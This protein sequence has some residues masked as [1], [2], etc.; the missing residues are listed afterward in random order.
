MTA[1]PLRHQRANGSRHIIAMTMQ[2]VG[3]LVIDPKTVL[4]WLASRLGASSATV[5]L[6]VPIREAGAL[7]PQAALLAFV[8]RRSSRK[9]LWTAGAFGQAATVTGLA[10][11]AFLRP[12]LPGAWILGLMVAFALARSLSSLTSKDVL[13]RTIP[14]GSRGRVSGT[15]TAASGLVVISVGA[16]LRAQPES[17]TPARTLGWLFV[18]AAAAWLIAGAVYAT[19]HEPG[20]SAEDDGAINSPIRHS[21]SV[22]REDAAFRRFVIAR[23]LLLVSSLSAPFIVLLAADDPTL[24]GLGPF[25]I[26]S[27]IAALLGG[28][29]WGRLADRSSR[30]TMMAAAAIASSLIIVFLLLLRQPEIAAFQWLYPTTYLLLALVHTGT[31]VGRKTYV[32]DLAEGD[33]RT[34]RVAISNAVMGALLLATG[35]VTAGVSLFGPQAAL[36]FLAVIGAIGVLVSRTLPE[37][38]RQRS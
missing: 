11:V 16:W 36:L 17:A 35:G 13:G 2:K 14:K 1:T 27:G 34:D 4:S 5:A 19:I 29:L 25:V 21:I 8:R 37:V 22:L 10:L 15:A 33:E 30:M 18:A 7:L 6:L 3:D 26:G 31:R 20:S 9:W 23:A 24:R 12:P 32:V 38:S 28:R